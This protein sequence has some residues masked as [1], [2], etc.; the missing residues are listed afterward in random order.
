MA[1]NGRFALNIIHFAGKLGADIRGLIDMT[2]M[3]A[4]E[5]SEE[6]CMLDDL[7]YNQIVE[8]SV[9]LSGD[10]Y[11]GL[12]AGE[13]LNLS[14]AGLIAQLTQ[15]SETVKQALELCCEFANLGC[16]ALPM[17]LVEEGDCYKVTM[18]PNPIW[19]VQ[20]DVAVRHTT[21]G[22][23]AFNIKEFHSLTRMKHS[24]VK[25][26][27][28]WERQHN[29]EELE[30]VY[31]CLVCFEKDE[32]AIFLNK[33]HVEEKIVTSDYNLLRIL[34]AHAEEKSAGI[35]TD[36]GFAALVKESVVNL[37]KPE[38][39]TIEQ[40]A[41]HLNVSPRTLQR[42]LKEEGQNFKDIIENLRKDFALSYLKRSDLSIGEVAYLLSYADISAFTRA[43]KRWMG[44]T[45]NDYRKGILKDK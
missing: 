16:S 13:N 28:T 27:L 19:A 20:S 39:P 22:V 40:V 43:F 44:V 24:P 15:T 2:G 18:T 30:R 33:S 7:T 45:P 17:A 34:I 21:E 32:I 29:V 23:I 38:F 36:K 25:I 10:P 12:H 8:E 6:T 3:S 11:F 42:R 9:A 41:S 31:G 37:V 26:H 1:F 14:A 5:L 35:K 4:S